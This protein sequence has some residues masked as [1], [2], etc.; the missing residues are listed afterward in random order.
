MFTAAA[1][2]T[3]GSSGADSC[4]CHRLQGEGAQGSE[5]GGKKK[6]RKGGPVQ[7]QCGQGDNLSLSSGILQVRAGR[8]HLG[9]RGGVALWPKKMTAGC[10]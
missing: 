1:V 7:A 2:H 10:I 4:H 5:K 6:K 8:G 3:Y 9:D